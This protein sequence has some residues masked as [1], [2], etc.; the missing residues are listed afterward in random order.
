M[1]DKL[2]LD[3]LGGASVRVEPDRGLL[4]R[5]DD[6]QAELAASQ[7]REQQSREALEVVLLVLGRHG[8][9]VPS[10][11]A[12][13]L[14]TPADDTAL[15]EQNAKLLRKMAME[16]DLGTQETE[17]AAITLCRKAYELSAAK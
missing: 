17:D 8:I 4:G 13:A 12:S 1:I 7:A 11:V 14:A 15:R 9:G 3:G 6:L 5:I 2:G 10:I 16:I